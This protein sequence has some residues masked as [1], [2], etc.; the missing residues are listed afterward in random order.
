MTPQKD[1]FGGE[2][3]SEPLISVRYNGSFDRFR[4]RNFSLSGKGFSREL[5]PVLRKLRNIAD[6]AGFHL[7]LVIIPCTKS[8]LLSC[9][10][11]R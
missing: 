7:T 4:D 11:L 3:C 5:S 6:Q 10:R 8:T 2:A 1:L 9:R